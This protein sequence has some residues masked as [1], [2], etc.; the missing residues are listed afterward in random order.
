M[1]EADYRAH[2]AVGL[3]DLIRRRE[4]TA[5]EALEAAIARADAV[6]PRINAINVP[7]YERA[8]ASVPSAAGDG[9]LAG[10]P[11]LLK[12]LGA[13]L[14]GVPTSAGSKVFAT[15]PAAGDNAIV[16]AYGGAGLVIFGKTNT[17]EFGLE[18][19]TE[20]ELFGPSRNP[21]DLQR[22]PGG[23]S[24][25]AAAAVAA[26][27][28]PAAHASD[29]G[30][31]IRIPA[32]C[33]GLF[34]MKPSRGRVSMA[35]G[36]EGWGGFSIQH[37]VSRTVRDSALLLDIVSRPQAGDPYWA[38]PPERLFAQEVGCEVGQLKVAFTTQ[39]I[40][41]GAIDPLCAEA[42]RD[43]ARLC[44]G[45]GH[46]VEEIALDWDY[47]PVRE[48]GGLIIA[49]NIATLLNNEAARRGREIGEDEVDAYTLALYRRGREM[50]A[51]DY[52]RALQTAHAFGRTAARTFEGFDVLLTST[53]GCPPPPVGWLREGGPGEYAKRLFDFMPNTQAFNIT[54]QPAMTVPLVRTAEGLPLGIQFVGQPA[55]EGVLFRL[56]AQL[57]EARPWA[58]RR[59]TV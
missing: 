7:L 52:I 51:S 31:S 59:P 27:I 11:F 43:A 37:A 32:S 22:T 45:L 46:H 1:N 12:D 56:A 41:S 49:A 47:E 15:T 3:A 30:G 5:S 40:A 29:G 14:A 33:C 9:P 17:P 34:G 24:G 53:L 38:E 57:E 25:G 16:T 36:D 21:W 10:V 6:N 58:F 35:P 13:Y 23:S 48:A 18:P 2:D 54:G 55:G 19:V 50:T 26:G 28:V 4:I 8:R 20:P 42:V 44:E 39:A